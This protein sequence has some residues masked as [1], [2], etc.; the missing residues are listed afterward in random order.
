[1]CNNE[2]MTDTNTD[3]T[4]KAQQ[5]LISSLKNH[6]RAIIQMTGSIDNATVAEVDALLTQARTAY[7][8]IV[9][10]ADNYKRLTHQIQ[11]VPMERV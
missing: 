1:M 9:F 4:I 8:Q 6:R 5:E 7:G 11:G 10:G 3:T 2:D